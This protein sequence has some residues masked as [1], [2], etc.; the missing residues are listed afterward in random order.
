M[1]LFI[2]ILWLL[3]MAGLFVWAWG[4]RISRRVRGWL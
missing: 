1:N 2:R 3:T 4:Y